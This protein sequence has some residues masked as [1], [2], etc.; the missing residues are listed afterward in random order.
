[1]GAPGPLVLGACLI[2]V[3]GASCAAEPAIGGS[4]ASLGPKK[5]ARQ[6]PR[7]FAR[8]TVSLL[9]RG[10]LVAGRRAPPPW[11]AV[12][13]GGDAPP[14]RV[15][16]GPALAGCRG[17]GLEIQ[18]DGAATMLARPVAPIAATASPILRWSWKVDHPVRT[19]RLDQKDRDDAAGRVLLGFRYEP[20]HA[21]TAERIARALRTGDSGFAPGSSLCYVWS[22]TEPVGAVLPSPYTDHVRVIVLRS[23]SGEA[24]AWVTEQRDV[25]AD[26]VRAFGRQPPPLERVAIMAD[27]DQTGASAVACFRDIALTVRN[28][29]HRRLPRLRK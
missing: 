4:D 17:W 8:R 22:A 24:G 19:A 1:L 11:R 28:A 14:A 2:G 7:A 12:D 5:V 29:P 13:L 26:Y 25:V 23:G 6:A 16:A 10:M 9:D 15:E 20:E 3:F 27:T 18:A 21:S